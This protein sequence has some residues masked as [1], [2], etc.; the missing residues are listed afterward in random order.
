V[1]HA[2]GRNGD[3]SDV[4]AVTDGRVHAAPHR[5]KPKLPAASQDVMTHIGTHVRRLWLVVGHL[6]AL[7][8]R[9]ERS[10]DSGPLRIASS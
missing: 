9:R 8:A 1:G 2:V 10:I 4:L 5:S 6:V 3:N 7:S